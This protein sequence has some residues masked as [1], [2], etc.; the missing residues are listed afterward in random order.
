MMKPV[1]N[2]RGLI[3]LEFLHLKNEE[4]VD[5]N[6]HSPLVASFVV[7]RQKGRLL[8]VFNRYRQCWELPSGRIETG[9]TPRECA[10]RELTEE[11][12]QLADKLDFTGIAKI[13]SKNGDITFAAV[14]S[15][16]LQTVL[17]FE[18]N[19]EI[20]LTTYWDFLSDIGYIDE[21]D[22]YIATLIVSG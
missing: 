20:E 18:A 12:G 10:F 11:S 21:I 8:L 22:R 15:C 3:L 17:P 6:I 13:S 19:E 2:K 9:E 7:A 14:Y 16:Y 4:D 5:L 1:A